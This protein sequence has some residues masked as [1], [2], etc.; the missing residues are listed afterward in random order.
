MSDN[1]WLW[2]KREVKE[3]TLEPFPLSQQWRKKF[4]LYMHTLHRDNW[5]RAARP[6]PFAA[7]S[8]ALGIWESEPLGFSPC[9]FL[10]PWGQLS[11]SWP[12]TRREEVC[13][14]LHVASLVSLLPPTTGYEE[15]EA[16]FILSLEWV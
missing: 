9:L 10:S 1:H 8:R 16:C 7:F 6:T 5:G 4:P 11:S 3:V 15:V 13:R 2:K 12:R 14:V